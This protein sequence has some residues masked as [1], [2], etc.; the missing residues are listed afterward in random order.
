MQIP[1]PQ[2]VVEDSGMREVH[3]LGDVNYVDDT[4]REKQ[5]ELGEVTVH[6]TALLVQSHEDLRVGIEKVKMN[7]SP[8]RMFDSSLYLQNLLQNTVTQSSLSPAEP[9]QR[10]P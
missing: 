1:L 5:V 7:K 4:F 2:E 3:G 9:G 10:R 8:T 6:K